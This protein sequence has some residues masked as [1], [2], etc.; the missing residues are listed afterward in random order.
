MCASTSWCTQGRR[1]QLAEV[2]EPT[3]WSLHLESP[4]DLNIRAS[5]LVGTTVHGPVLLT[6][7]RPSPTKSK[8]GQIWMKWRDYTL[9]NFWLG[10]SW[11][12]PEVVHTRMQMSRTIA[13][14]PHALRNVK[15]W[16]GASPTSLL[17]GYCTHMKVGKPVY[18][19]SSADDDPGQVE[20]VA[21]VTSPTGKS[22]EGASGPC[23]NEECARQNAALRLLHLLQSAIVEVLGCGTGKQGG[24]KKDSGNS[25]VHIVVKGGDDSPAVVPG[26]EVE[27]SY[28]LSTKPQGTEGTESSAGEN[29]EVIIEFQQG[30]KFEVGSGVV[31]EEM[32]Y[33]VKHLQFG[34]RGR[35]R[36]DSSLEGTDPLNKFESVPLT[37]EVELLA[38]KVPNGESQQVKIFSPPLGQQ[39]YSRAADCLLQIQPTRLLDLGCG[40]G[41]LLETLLGHAQFGTV[42]QLVG[43]DVSKDKLRSPARVKKA[44]RE[45][46]MNDGSG[47]AE[48][49]GDQNGSQLDVKLFFGNVLQPG[50]SD[51]ETWGALLGI[52]AVAMIEVVEHLDTE[53]LRCVGSAILGSLKPRLFVASTPNWEYNAVLRELGGCQGGP[54]GRDGTPMRCSD[55]RFEWTRAEF[56][57]WGQKLADQFGYSVT[58]E[59]IG[60]AI[61]EAEA[62]QV[63]EFQQTQD[64]GSASQ[65]AVFIRGAEKSVPL[66]DV[67]E[68]CQGL[69]LVWDLQEHR[70]EVWDAVGV[71]GTSEVR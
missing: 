50:M 20:W 43:I 16:R 21:S 60:H 70:S 46:Q 38:A 25:A 42:R 66:H 17:E 29:G 34:G 59:G 5:W 14:L 58:F 10:M 12:C 23:I 36:K 61:N 7:C 67:S 62:L 49:S 27:V 22:L 52:D 9:Q 33:L 53:P 63:E 35:M 69:E 65:M 39:R 30:F 11:N 19:C 15:K 6:L 13:K 8:N 4:Q 68:P 24:I 3:M 31:C 2:K 64:V 45:M 57:D 40:E 32:D 28:C 1:A 37:L 26:M 55:H 18:K 51:P 54:P 47:E 56:E 41:R 44:L 71:D 48:V